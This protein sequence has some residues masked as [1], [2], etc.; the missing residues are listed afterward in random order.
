M[1]AFAARGGERSLK[2]ESGSMVWI[3][4]VCVPLVII[5]LVISW[6][7][8]RAWVGSEGTTEVGAGGV[9]EKAPKTGPDVE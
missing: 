1:Y 8:G 5:M 6:L 3:P 2:M 4:I 7:L 9:P